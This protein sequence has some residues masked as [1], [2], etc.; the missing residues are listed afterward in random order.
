[1]V[2]TIINFNFV[3]VM[4]YVNWEI[5]SQLQFR[6][7][8]V[9]YID[10]YVNVNECVLMATYLVRDFWRNVQIMSSEERWIIKCLTKENFEK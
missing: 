5:N 2:N 4:E 8:I 1:M 9:F 7:R 6:D 10:G 3:Y